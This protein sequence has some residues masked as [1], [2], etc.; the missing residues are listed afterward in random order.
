MARFEGSG[1]SRR[2]FAAEAGVGLAIFQDLAVQAPAGAA[3][4]G[5]AEGAGDGGP[6]RA[7]DGQGAAHRRSA[8]VAGL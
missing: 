6:P 7:G 8:S 4:D 5:G 1:R 2:E 3:G